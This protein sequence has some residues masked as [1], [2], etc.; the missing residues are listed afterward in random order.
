[1]SNAAGHRSRVPDLLFEDQCAARLQEL[2]PFLEVPEDLG[3]EFPLH[4]V[5]IFLTYRCNLDCPYCKTIAR[6]EEELQARPE[7]RLTYS[8]E[9]FRER[10]DAWAPAPIRH[11]HFTGG[12]A[13]LVRDLPA[14]LRL[15]RSR[16]VET[17]S[18]TS[19]GTLPPQTYVE[20]VEA[21]LDEIRISLDAADTLLGRALSG[22]PRAWEAAVRTIRVLASERRRGAD[23]FLIVNTVVTPQNRGELARIVDFLLT[24][25]PDDIKLITSVD[26]K[27]RLG[28]FPEAPAV[29]DGILRLLEPYPPDRFPLLRRKVGTVFAQDA[30]GLSSPAR[31][32]PDGLRCFIPLTERTV[33]G[34]FYYPCSVYLREGGA[35]LGELRDS[36]DKQRAKSAAFVR[37]ADCSTDPICRRYC[38]HCTRQYNEGAQRLREAQAGQEAPHGA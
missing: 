28:N 21:G 2:A 36:P 1:M 32:S 6:S 4:R 26:E 13:G 22:R 24:L 29:L 10:L 7:K 5:T 14:M 23:F 34:R 15:A 19:N 3:E 30:I 9:D 35:P 11:L 8:L 31:S 18:L 17:L 33:D 27:E 20:L 37:R 12:E 25:D 38:L 16:G